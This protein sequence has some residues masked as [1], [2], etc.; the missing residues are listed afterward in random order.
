MEFDNESRSKI[1]VYLFLGLAAFFILY[2]LVLMLLNSLKSNFEIFVNPIGLP[3]DPNWGV[4][5]QVWTEA[6]LGQAI[7]NSLFI[8]LGTVASVCTVTSMAAWVIARRNVPGW[9]LISLYFLVTTTIPI[10]M[11][12]F[13][14]Y[15]VM[16][17]FGLINQPLAVI[18]IYTAIFTPFSLFLLR[19][20]IVEI[21][22]ELEEAARIDGASEAQIF[23]RVILPLIKPG[24]ITVALITGLSAWN[25]FL[26]AVTFLQT[27]EDATATAR[28]YQLIGRFSSNWAEQMAIAAM[29]AIPVV[30]FF[31]LLQRRFIEGVSSG[32]VK[33]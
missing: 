6:N 12:I 27:G 23:F 2:P 29:I 9:F 26:I 13:P 33:G 10:Q 17:W 11:Y 15:F 25:E 22:V 30:V 1:L 14:L 24:L 4:F 20:Y 28:F 18:Y 3:E 5:A 19:T 16:G 21:P 32:A 7:F 8:A 31:V